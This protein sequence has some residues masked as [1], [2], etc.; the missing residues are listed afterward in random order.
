MNLR[1]TVRMNGILQMMLWKEK[2]MGICITGSTEDDVN[3]C[4]DLESED[5][6]GEER[7]IDDQKNAHHIGRY[8]I[9]HQKELSYY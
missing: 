3:V 1:I 7:K 5:V 4:G 9:T 2:N 8:S 6:E